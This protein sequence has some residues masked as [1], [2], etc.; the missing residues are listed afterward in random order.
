VLLEISHGVNSKLISFWNKKNYQIPIKSISAH[1]NQTLWNAHIFRLDAQTTS[2]QDLSDNQEGA[3]FGH[4]FSSPVPP[5]RRNVHSSS[6]IFFWK[7]GKEM[8]YNA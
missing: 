3:G 6:S 1:Y 4:G 8:F 7:K 2:D 5:V